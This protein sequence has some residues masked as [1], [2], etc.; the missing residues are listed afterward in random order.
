M[1]S[2]GHK[3]QWRIL[4]PTDGQ[5]SC[6]GARRLVRQ[7]WTN[8]SK[9]K[10]PPPPPPRCPQDR[11]AWTV[12]N[13]K[14]RDNSRRPHK[15]KVPNTKPTYLLTMLIHTCYLPWLPVSDR[16]IDIRYLNSLNRIYESLVSGHS[17]YRISSCIM[18]LSSWYSHQLFNL[19]PI[20][21]Q[22]HI[23]NVI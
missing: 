1:E 7:S 17:C 9:N 5:P 21:T 11:G 22:I 8:N 16:I 10:L 20:L 18:H 12:P 14:S 19:S 15:D 2:P 13:N 4:V 23:L 6:R 3:I